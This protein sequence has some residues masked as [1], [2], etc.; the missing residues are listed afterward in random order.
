MR[1]ND[2]SCGGQPAFVAVLPTEDGDWYLYGSDLWRDEP[3]EALATQY[4]AQLSFDS[5]GFIEQFDCLAT[6]DLVTIYGTSGL[7]PAPANVDATSAGGAFTHETDAAREGRYTAQTFAA[8]R[9]G[10]LSTVEVVAFQYG[11]PDAPLI[12]DVVRWNEDNTAGDVLGSTTVEASMVGWSARVVTVSPAMT[13][14]AGD[15]LAIIVR[16]DATQGSYGVASATDDPYTGGSA[17]RS[18]DGELWNAEEGVDLSF[19]A[20]VQ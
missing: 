13:V 10:T 18:T 3:N 8:S 2:T 9:G 7:P 11:E 5:T 16:S 19:R 20:F 14:A 15:K 4:W 12:L 17:F 6:V 1:V